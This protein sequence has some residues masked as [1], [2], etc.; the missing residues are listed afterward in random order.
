MVRPTGD[1]YSSLSNM[2]V[3]TETEIAGTTNTL[4]T[5]EKSVAMSTYLTVFVVSDF[6]SKTVQ[7]TP[8]NPEDNFV[9]SVY[10]TNE[11]LEKTQYALDTGKKVIEY[12]IDYFGIKYPLPKL[13]R[14]IFNFFYLMIFLRITN[15]KCQMIRV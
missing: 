15:T 12:Y 6:T 5:F 14:F 2:P 1:G 7:I 3:L 11:Q 13:G 4:T 10:A 9:M 8:A